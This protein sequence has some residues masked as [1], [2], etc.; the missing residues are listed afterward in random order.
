VDTGLFAT[1]LEVGLETSRTL[2]EIF[3]DVPDGSPLFERFSFVDADQLPSLAQLSASTD[4]SNLDSLDSDN[5]DL[6]ISLALKL[7]VARHRLGLITEDIQEVVVSA[8]KRIKEALG[9]DNELIEFFDSTQISANLSIQ[10]N[11]LFGRAAYGQANA[12]EKLGKLIETLIEELDLKDQ[13]LDVGLDYKVGVGGARLSS[14]QRQKITLARA[15]IKQPD[16]L[17]VNEALTR[18]NSSFASMLKQNI[19]ER[20]AGR[21]VVWVLGNNES[22][23]GFDKLILLDK[24]KLIAQGSEEEIAPHLGVLDS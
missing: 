17:V 14:E 21:T 23:D 1:L 4:A 2:V 8:Q 3:S 13:V 20:M 11:I 7:T 24:G 18:F 15:L 6:L 19:L 16:I 22:R 10:D 12:Q 9:D 5:Q